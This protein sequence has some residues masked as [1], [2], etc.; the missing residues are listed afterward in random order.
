MT[1]QSPYS[2]K[3]F[4]SEQKIEQFSK[5]GIAIFKCESNHRYRMDGKFDG[6][7]SKTNK[8]SKVFHLMYCLFIK[9][10]FY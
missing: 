4:S 7:R 1:L 10:P 5:T 8:L 6:E 2:L 9:I 3:E